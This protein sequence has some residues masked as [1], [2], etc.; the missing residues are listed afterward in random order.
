MA[1]IC[2][3]APA[4]KG[5]FSGLTKTVTNRYGT[6]SRIEDH[7]NSY[8]LASKATLPRSGDEEADFTQRDGQSIAL[9]ETPR[10]NDSEF[11]DWRS[12]DAK[13][14]VEAKYIED[15]CYRGNWADS[16]SRSQS[17]ATWTAVKEA[18]VSSEIVKSP[19][20]R[21]RMQDGGI[22]ITETFTV[23]RGRAPFATEK[24]APRL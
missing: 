11:M 13:A 8:P 6:K 15:A 14:D 7:S 5:F 22:L 4:M 20:S 16:D 1:L 24:K 23:E 19:G 21:T 3:S 9:Y 17:D 2:A 12:S 18:K 10:I